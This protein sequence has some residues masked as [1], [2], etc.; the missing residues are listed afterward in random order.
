MAQGSELIAPFF[1]DPAR[2]VDEA[3]TSFRLSTR[4]FFLLQPDEQDS[5]SAAWTDAKDPATIASTSS[6]DLLPSQTPNGSQVTYDASDVTQEQ[7]PANSASLVP[8][9]HFV[10]GILALCLAYVVLK[11]LGARS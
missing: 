6:G 3:I 7:A 4:L 9:E 10:A 5:R 11:A 2:L 1:A 8:V